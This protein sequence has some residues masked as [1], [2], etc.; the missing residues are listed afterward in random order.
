MKPWWLIAGLWF[1]GPAVLAQEASEPQPPPAGQQTQPADEAEPPVEADDLRIVATKEQVEG[2]QPGVPTQVDLSGSEVGVSVLG[3]DSLVITANEHDLAILEALLRQ[4]DRDMPSKELRVVKLEERPAAEVATNLQQAIRELYPRDEERPE[5]RTS[6]TAVSSNI[7]LIVAPANKVDQV[8]KLAKAIDAVRPPI[9][10]EMMVFQVKNRKATE[11]AERLREI[12]TELRKKQGA[13]AAQEFTIT[14]NDA[15]GTIV[16]FGPVAEKNTIQQ[17]LNQIDVEAVPGYGELKLVLF[18]LVN[19]DAKDLATLFEEM[20]KTAETREGIEEQMRRLIMLR[21][22]PGQEPVELPPLDL[23]KTLRI[24][25]HEGTNS[26]LVA[27]V[28]ENIEPVGEIIAMLDDAPLSVDMGLRIFALR[29]ADAETVGEALKE[30]FDEG[31]K[32][33]KAPEGGKDIGGAVPVTTEGEALVYNVT[34]VPDPRTNTL[35]VAGRPAQLSIVERVVQEMDQPANALKFPLRLL[36]LGDNIDATRVGKIIEDLVAKRVEAFE[37]QKIGS[38]AIEREKVFLAVDI[39]SNALI[40]SASEENLAEIQQ[41]VAQLDTAPDRLIDNIR[42]ITCQNTSAA[43]LA[44]KIGELWDR[45]AKLRQEGDIPEDLPVIVA[46]QRSNSLVIAS[47]PEDFQ[48]ITRLIEKLEAQPLAPIAAIRLIPLVNNDASEISKMFED[49]FQERMEQ[50]LAKGQEE[51]PSDRVALAFDA[52]TN[53][54]LVASSKENYDEMARIVGVLDAEPDIEG[55]V[56]TFVLQNAEA[57]KTADTIKELFDQGLYNPSTGLDSTLTEE[58]M[59][60]AIVA[61]ARANAVI[62]SASKPNMSIIGRLVEQMDNPETPLRENTRLFALEYADAVKLTDMLKRLF[63]G[64]KQQAPDPDIF[65]EPTIIADDR[66][67]M[68]IVSGTR[69]GLK[70]CEDLIAQLDRQAGPPTSVF[71]IFA[72]K[73]ASAVKLAPIMQ[74][75]FE[76]RTEGQEDERTP[77][78]IFADEGSNT[79]ICSAAREDIAVVQSLLTL[80]DKP[81]TIARQFAIFPLKRAKAE[82][83][84]QRLDE[85]FKTRMEGAGDV[86]ADAIAVQPDPRTNS[87]IV[88]ASPTE[89]ENIST[90][91]AKLDTTDPAVEMGVRVIQLKQARAEDLATVLEESLVGPDAGG[92]EDKAVIISYWTVD[93][94]G[95]RDQRKLVRQDITITPE[96]RTNTLTVIAPADSMDMLETLIRDFDKIRPILAEVRL[97]PLVNADAEEVVQRLQDLFEEQAAE[98]G[99]QTLVFGGEGGTGPGTVGGEGGVRQQLRFAADRRTN[100]VIA[101]GSEVDLGMVERLIYQLDAQDSEERVF[102]VYEAKNST[103]EALTQAIRDFAQA[104]Q[105]RLS[106]LEDETSIM[107]QAERHVTVIGDEQSNSV[108]LGVSPRF[109]DQ[110]MTLIQE[111]DR[112]PPQ[113]M[114]QVLIA[115]V[116]LDDRVELGMEFTGQDLLFTENA[117]QGPNGTVLG[118]DKDF[119]AGTNLGAAGSTLG[120]FNFT[121]TGEDFSFLLKALAGDSRLEVLSRPTLMVENNEEANITIGDRVPIVQGSTFTDAGN[122]STQVQY[123]DVGIIMDVTP[124]INPDGFVNLEIHPEISQVSDSSVQLTEGLAAPIISERSAE[125]VVTVKDG[126]TVVIGGLITNTERES[127]SKV[128]LVGDVPGLGLLFRSTSNS[129]RKTE[130]LIV[131]TVNVLRSIEDVRTLSAEQR[132]KSG[133]LEN[134]ARNPLMEGLRIRAEEEGLAPSETAPVEPYPAAPRD[135]DLYGPTPDVYGPPTPPPTRVEVN[136]SP[137]A[138]VARQYGPVIP[139][140]RNVVATES[141]TAADPGAA[142][143]ALGNPESP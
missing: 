97:F 82:P 25:A 12:I 51:N 117:V 69:D 38:S 130:L 66:S 9:S 87:L 6:I 58:R 44:S 68:L 57:T 42:I 30:M 71:E 7:L 124:H 125:T 3:G 17:I 16:V 84:S 55:V 62:V 26:L 52:P 83:L 15:D 102:L 73:F 40:L 63:E 118:H 67:N 27:T 70:R 140:G 88:W 59:K 75:M 45:K 91:I 122:T 114:I 85:M 137:A 79:L 138:P 134:I 33:T 28:E 143:L 103:A 43:D 29:F 92:E 20:L 24:L 21:R 116:T 115:E 61:D 22:V 110:Y 93:A 121:I 18:P 123:E 126:E 48:E 95:V 131:L 19:T 53:T 100:T 50:R 4:W 94:D 49:L 139:G 96:E 142:R 108:V 107:R 77:I 36:F 141:G 90:I 13:D 14:P 8:V 104:E 1:L 56:K 54:I 39:R 129:N 105:D 135:R 132:D 34:I 46:D 81:S 78:N 35:I 112:P 64:M 74:D 65:I 32:L 120:G 99:E 133:L 111:L 41:I 119:V 136:P 2:P 5:Q 106:Q 98:E 89:M 127:E 37:A 128:P 86:R 47:S 76:K 109:Y 72:L 113:V 101:A 10:A 11:A 31:R 80:L 23:E 60:I